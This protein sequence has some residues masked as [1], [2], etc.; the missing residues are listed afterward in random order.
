MLCERFFCAFGSTFA[1]DFGQQTIPES[2][3]IMNFDPKTWQPVAIDAFGH[4]TA[5]GTPTDQPSQWLRIYTT[6]GGIIDAKRCPTEKPLYCSR[7]GHFF[8]LTDGGATLR[9]VKPSFVPPKNTLVCHTRYPFMSNFGCRACHHL[10]YET[11]VGTR[12]PGMEIDHINGNVTDWSL[13]NL[14]EVTPAENRKRA[15][16]LRVM[17]DCGN[18]PTQLPSA[19]LKNIFDKYEFIDNSQCTMHN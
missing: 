10:M 16:I 18:D 13:D 1:P 2:H 14:E 6:D 7:D 17:R 19:R 3:A 5:Q 8:S 15:K 4:V 12:T 9:E 11:W